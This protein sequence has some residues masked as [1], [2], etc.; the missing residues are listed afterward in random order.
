MDFVR[1]IPPNLKN[2]M[3]ADFINWNNRTWDIRKIK[4]YPA[5]DLVNSDP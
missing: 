5:K 1:E 4:L 3:V 2:L